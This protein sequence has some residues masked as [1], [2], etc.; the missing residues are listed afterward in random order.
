MFR[1]ERKDVSEQFLSLLR[2][3][4]KPSQ[5]KPRFRAGGIIP[6]GSAQQTGRTL[7]VSLSGQR[8]GCFHRDLGTLSGIRLPNWL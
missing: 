4:G 2:A 7:Q 3:F 6:Y 1:V 5:A 8:S